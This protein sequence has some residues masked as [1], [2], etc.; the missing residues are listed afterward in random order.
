M[1]INSVGQNGAINK[2]VDSVNKNAEKSAPVVNITDKLELSEGAQ[3]FSELLK[4]AKSEME[5]LGVQD[6]LK[7]S[8]I[9][10]RIKNGSYKVEDGDLVASILKGYAERV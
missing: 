9:V 2:Y 4:A 5:K 10:E 7:T 1:K 3:K 8:D 6:E